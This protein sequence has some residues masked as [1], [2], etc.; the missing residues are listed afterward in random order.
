MLWGS[1]A[2]E[3]VIGTDSNNNTAS[4]CQASRDSFKMLAAKGSQYPTMHREKKQFQL[5]QFEVCKVSVRIIIKI[6]FRNNE[7]RKGASQRDRKPYLLIKLL[8]SYLF[9]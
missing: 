7:R 9:V 5:K 3:L 8:N 1:G 4:L 2:T 6:V